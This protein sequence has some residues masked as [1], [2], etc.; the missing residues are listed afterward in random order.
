MGMSDT[1]YRIVTERMIAALQRG[2]VPWR[3][4]WQTAAGQ[5]RSMSTGQPYRGVNVFLLGMAAAEEGYSSP[6]WGTYRQINA[7]GGQVRKGEHSTPVVFWKLAQTEHRDPQTGEITLKLLPVLRYYR[8]FNAVQADHLPER[9]HPAPGEY[10]EIAEPQTVLDG[11]LTGGPK[12][13]HF[14]GDRADYH[15]LTDTIRLPLRSQ[16]HTSEG[17]YATAFHEAGHS[18]GH[19]ARLNRPGIAAFDHFGSGKYAREELVAQMS[20]SILC[21]E[22]GIEDQEVFENSASYIAGW[23]SA[24]NDDTKLVI[25]AAAQAQRACDLINQAEREPTKDSHRRAE[26]MPARDEHV[27]AETTAIAADRLRA[28]HWPDGQTTAAPNH[29]ELDGQ[30]RM[31]AHPEPRTSPIDAD[32]TRGALDDR[33]PHHTPEALMR[34]SSADATRPARAST[35]PGDWQAEAG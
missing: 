27:P 22:T 18:T 7:L 21:A 35:R 23:L 6:F 10:S 16:F 34:P 28:S 19:P 32:T 29:R 25:I 14:A 33:S 2:S 3:K 9:F 20:S 15:P 17:Y 4:P 13:V 24:L 31:A 8:V 30:P 12:L 11:Y 1:V 5:L 26:I